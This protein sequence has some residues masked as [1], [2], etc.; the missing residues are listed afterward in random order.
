MDIFICIFHHQFF[1][2]SHKFNKEIIM[3]KYFSFFRGAFCLRR[4]TKN[5]LGFGIGTLVGEG[6]RGDERG[7]GEEGGG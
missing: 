1:Q 7:R 2:P 6:M 4:K 5:K 3:E